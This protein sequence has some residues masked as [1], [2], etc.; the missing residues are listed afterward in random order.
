MPLFLRKRGGQ[1]CCGNER[2]STGDGKLVVV[3]KL[4]G[5][6]WE[7]F[8]PSAALLQISRTWDPE[9]G[10]GAQRKGNPEGTDCC[11]GGCMAGGF[12]ARPPPPEP[13]DN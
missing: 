5:D 4:L 10:P 12:I 7:I 9:G 3:A 1:R 2:G 6:R 13:C 8:L 11:P